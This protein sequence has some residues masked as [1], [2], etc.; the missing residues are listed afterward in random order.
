MLMAYI[1]WSLPHKRSGKLSQLGFLNTAIAT[2][3]YDYKV[4]GKVHVRKDGILRKTESHYD[5]T[6]QFMQMAQSG[7]KAE[8]N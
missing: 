7:L 8:A 5:R 3:D 4:G 6:H 1:E 2:M